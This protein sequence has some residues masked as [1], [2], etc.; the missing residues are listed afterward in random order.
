MGHHEISH[1]LLMLMLTNTFLCGFTYFILRFGWTDDL[2]SQLYVKSNPLRFFH[3]FMRL[4][5]FNTKSFGGLK[6]QNVNDKILEGLRAWT[7]N[8]VGANIDSLTHCVYIFGLERSLAMDQ[9][10]QKHA[11]SPNINFIVVA[12]LQNHFWSHILISPTESRSRRVDLIGGPP[13]VTKLYVVVLVQEQI[14]R[15]G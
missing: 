7:A 4:N 8:L 5:L 14:L 15:L 9:L 6:L 2:K 10:K 11:Q 13:K 1:G 3:P 12:L